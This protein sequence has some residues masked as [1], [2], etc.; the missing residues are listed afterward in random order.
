M[1][2][3]TLN[4]SVMVYGAKM[5][6]EGGSTVHSGEI[7][8]NPEYPT[9][10]FGQPEIGELRLTVRDDELEVYR[11]GHFFGNFPWGVKNETYA[12]VV[13]SI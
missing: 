8:F 6:I 5:R 13:F 9:V 7:Q 4:L 3:H 11:N 1:M 2:T 10:H 12:R